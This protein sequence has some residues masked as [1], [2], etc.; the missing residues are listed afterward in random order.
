M[1]RTVRLLKVVYYVPIV[2]S[3]LLASCFETGFFIPGSLYDSGS[4]QAEFIATTVMELLAICVIPLSLRLF[5]FGKIKQSLPEK[6]GNLLRY[7]CI[8]LVLL[9][10]PMMANTLLYYLYMS[11]AFGYLAVILLLASVFI[12]PSASRCEAETANSER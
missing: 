6:P 4:P 11:A 9:M 2:V 10:L 7:G 5:R 3:L 12:Y 8:R 1:K